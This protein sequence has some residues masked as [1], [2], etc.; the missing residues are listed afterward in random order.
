MNKLDLG[1]AQIPMPSA[2]IG[3]IVRAP[4]GGAV[5]GIFHETAGERGRIF[6]VPRR[7]GLLV[8]ADLAAPAG[9]SDSSWR[10]SIFEP[11]VRDISNAIDLCIASK[12]ALQELWPEFGR[13]R[14]R[15]QLACQK[16][17]I[18][19]IFTCDRSQAS[20]VSQQLSR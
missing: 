9:E 17:T 18:F 12:R 11:I 19:Y 10:R 1:F 16:N 4:D 8:E 15:H 14:A 5:I 6:L 3:R 7:N 13:I 20:R 2:V